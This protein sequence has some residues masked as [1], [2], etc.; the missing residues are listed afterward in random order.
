VI[1]RRGKAYLRATSARSRSSRYAMGNE[2]PIRRCR[3]ASPHISVTNWWLRDTKGWFTGWRAV[4]SWSVLR[5]GKAMRR[6]ASFV[7][8]GMVALPFFGCI[9]PPSPAARAAPMPEFPWPPPTPTAVYVLPPGLVV[10]GQVDTLRHAFA[11]VRS[12]LYRARMYESSVYAIDSARSGFAVVTRIERIDTSG[13]PY[14]RGSRF[15]ADIYAGDEPRSFYDWLRSVFR[16]QPGFYRVVAFLI[17]DKPIV[18]SAPPITPERAEA[19]LKGGTDRLAVESDRT[20][21]NAQATALI[22]E[23]ERRNNVDSVSQ[24]RL[25]LVPPVQHLS[26]A[27]FWPLA[28]LVR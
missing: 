14:P 6:D 10:N 17:T 22:Y 27:G 16:A 23:F 2:K 1:E 4:P 11:R 28:Q 24:R 5:R 8:V 19:L 26:A 25:S 9:P 18:A 7:L 13:A 15:P 20:L 21:R 3:V 12:A